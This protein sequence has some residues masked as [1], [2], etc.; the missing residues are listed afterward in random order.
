VVSPLTMVALKSKVAAARRDDYR[1]AARFQIKWLRSVPAH[2]RQ[3][4][5][6]VGNVCVPSC[7][8]STSAHRHTIKS[9]SQRVCTPDAH[10][11]VEFPATRYWLPDRK[12]AQHPWLASYCNPAAPME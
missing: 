10:C 5:A 6:L 4:G 7:H 9:S 8:Y 11:V 12:S 3:S 2:H 1:C